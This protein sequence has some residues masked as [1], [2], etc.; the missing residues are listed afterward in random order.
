MTD[1]HLSPGRSLE[2]RHHCTGCEV[3]GEARHTQIHT[4]SLGHESYRGF[5][6]PLR[7]NGETEWRSG[8]VRACPKGLRKTEERTQ[9]DVKRWSNCQSLP[10][11]S[12]CGCPLHRW[13]RTP[14]K[15]TETHFTYKGTTQ[16]IN[17]E[18]ILHFQTKKKGKWE[19]VWL[20]RQ[21]WMNVWFNEEQNNMKLTFL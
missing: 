12:Y 1:T 4:G 18:V 21:E 16:S 20:R 9:F 5:L 15:H 17:V 11:S 19:V 8:G 6:A 3:P 2:K 13:T 10:L 7:W 14:L